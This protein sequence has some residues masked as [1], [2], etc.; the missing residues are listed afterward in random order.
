MEPAID[1]QTFWTFALD[2]Q[3]ETVVYWLLAGLK[4]I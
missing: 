4:R 2:C 1:R 3:T